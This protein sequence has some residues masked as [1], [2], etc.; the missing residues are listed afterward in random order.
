MPTVG[1]AVLLG[2]FEGMR[3]TDAVVLRNAGGNPVIEPARLL[4]KLGNEAEGNSEL[5]RFLSGVIF[6]EAGAHAADE[7][8]REALAACGS[9]G[10][11]TAGYCRNALR[12]YALDSATLAALKAFIE[13][14]P[15]ELLASLDFAG[16]SPYGQAAVMGGVRKGVELMRAVSELAGSENGML[17]PGGAVITLDVVRKAQRVLAKSL[18]DWS[19][20][21]L[22]S[23]AV[24]GR[25]R[26]L[27]RVAAVTYG[28]LLAR[29]EEAAEY[30]LDTLTSGPVADIFT[31][32]GAAVRVFTRF[33]GD[34]ALPPGID[35]KG[36]AVRRRLLRDF[37]FVTA[38]RRIRKRDGAGDEDSVRAEAD[39]LLRPGVPEAMARLLTLFLNG[40]L[41][42]LPSEKELRT[43]ANVRGFDAEG[44]HADFTRDCIARRHSF[45]VEH[46]GKMENALEREA[47]V[48]RGRRDMEFYEKQLEEMIRTGREDQARKWA[49]PVVRT[50]AAMTEEDLKSAQAFIMRGVPDRDMRMAVTAIANQGGLGLFEAFCGREPATGVMFESTD[51]QAVI[52]FSPRKGE[53][54]VRAEVHND[55]M[56]AVDRSG[57]GED[58]LEL[59]WVNFFLLEYKGALKRSKD[60]ACPS[61]GRWTVCGVTVDV[62]AANLLPPE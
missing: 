38:C 45:T 40:L 62:L 54:S 29:H 1:I 39:A 25:E 22:E 44:F 47:A 33:A 31:M 26:E 41:R 34:T 18:K 14:G 55:R 53:F 30:T 24:H 57:D 28:V 58:E 59:G 4:G 10:R 32:Q 17:G 37:L 35:G 12:R 19:A 9:G 56:R 52:I 3:E 43:R 13:E 6:Q 42:D 7:F 11:L 15:E 50:S 16:L 2:R 61:G 23:L 21:F 8:E 20:A 60:A 51:R 48:G 27:P 36:P 5:I 49:P 46:H